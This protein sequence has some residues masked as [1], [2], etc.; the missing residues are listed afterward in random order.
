MR[1]LGSGRLLIVFA[2]TASAMRHFVAFTF[3]GAD[4]ARG[5]RLFRTERQPDPRALRLAIAI[6]NIARADRQHPIR[7]RRSRALP[8]QALVLVIFSFTPSRRATLVTLAALGFLSFANVPG[9]AALRGS[10]C[11]GA[12]ARAV[13][14]A[15][16]A[17][18]RRLQSGYRA[19]RVLGGGW[20]SPLHSAWLPTRGVG[21]ILVGRTPA[22][23]LDGV[24]DRAKRCAGEPATVPAEILRN[25]ALPPECAA[26]NSSLHRQ[27]P[28]R[29]KRYSPG[30][31][32]NPGW[33]FWP[34][35]R[36]TTQPASNHD[37]SAS[38]R[39]GATL[40]KKIMKLTL[41]SY[42]REWFSNIRADAFRASSWRLT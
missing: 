20:V 35:I 42:K 22:H 39:P 29:I 12:P 19:R 28:G 31:G 32:E 3:L 25:I 15:S 13:D 16:G 38:R 37:K 36:Q 4:P 23:A 5:H 9:S 18:H 24:L 14:V 41:A 27:Q 10:A 17:E 7:S 8:A 1:V 26:H 6:G 30:P 34:P 40:A 33:L 11:Q 21:A 2:M